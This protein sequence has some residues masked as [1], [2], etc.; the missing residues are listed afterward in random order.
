MQVSQIHPIVVVRLIPGTQSTELHKRRIKNRKPIWLTTKSLSTATRNRILSKLREF[1][2]FKTSTKTTIKCSSQRS[3]WKSK[4][5]GRTTYSWEPLKE[6][7]FLQ[8]MKF[9]SRKDLNARFRCF[10]LGRR[11][12]SWK[13]RPKTTRRV[14]FTRTLTFKKDCQNWFNPVNWPILWKT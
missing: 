12:N 11:I 3:Q 6:R 10:L 8:G 7:N 9:Y 1:N 2:C 13:R 4:I 5:L 14:H